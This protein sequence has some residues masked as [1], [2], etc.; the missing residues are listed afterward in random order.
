[1]ITKQFLLQ[2]LPPVRD[3]WE[4]VTEDQDVNDIIKQILR[5]HEANKIYYDKIALYFDA[6]TVPEICD[7]IFDFEKSQIKYKE[8]SQNEQ[9]TAIPGGILSRGYGDC[10]HYASFAG[11]VLSGIERLTGKKIDWNY[12]FAS[13]QLWRPLPY[14]VFVV[15]RD[16]GKEYWI[17]PTPGAIGMQPVWKMDRK[18]KK[19][20]PLLNQIAGVGVG[21]CGCNGNG[22]AQVGS[23]SSIFKGIQH[24]AAG[25]GMQVPR[26]AFLVLVAL[27]AFGYATKLH[28]ALQYTDTSNKLFDIWWRLGGDNQKLRDAIEKG[29]KKPVNNDAL[30]GSS[31]QG[32]PVGYYRAQDG[33]VLPISTAAGG[34]DPFYTISGAG[35]GDIAA[36]AS[37][38]ASAAIIVAAIMPVISRL[39]DA[40]N[41]STVVNA[42]QID[43]TTGLPV[44]LQ[45]QRNPVVEFA[46]SNPLLVAAGV[47]LLGYYI[48]E[49]Y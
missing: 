23:F 37:I 7:N 5:A 33:S 44:G 46:Q 42:P 41:A 29:Y 20:M 36:A 21:D 19:Q 4:V 16:K 1:M 3:E 6:G 11:G 12:R 8:E 15:V 35:V 10:K 32:V 13:Y 26:S 22:H 43:P 40:H 48:Y 9:T 38:I 45:V 47:G 2:Q 31:F 30:Q 24:F 49:N 25:M 34:P 14:H 28:N 27:N 17:D 39:L 18:P